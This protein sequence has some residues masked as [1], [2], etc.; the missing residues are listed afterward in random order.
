VHGAALRAGGTVPGFGLGHF[1]ILVDPVHPSGV[2]HNLVGWPDS[3]GCPEGIFCGE[4]GH[5]SQ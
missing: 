1:D 3:K 5:G 2:H 4:D